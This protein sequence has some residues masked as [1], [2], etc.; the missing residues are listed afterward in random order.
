VTDPAADVITRLVR[1]EGGR[2]VAL[3]ARQTGDLDIAEEAAQEALIEAARLWP[4]GSI[5]DNPGGWLAVVARRKAIDLLRRRASRERRLAE[6]LADLDRTAPQPGED[7]PDPRLV[8]SDAI[9]DDQLRLLFLCCH[10]ALAPEAQVA[11]TLRLVAGL[12]TDEIA[13]AF[14]VSEPTLAQRLVR[15]K[16]KVR[17]ARIPLAIPDDLAER[18]DVVLG[19]IYLVFN[20]GYLARG[21]ESGHQ[22]VDLADEAIRLAR[23]LDRLSPGNAEVEGLLALMLFHHA[24]S[25]TR[26]SID[27]RL[28]PL[29]EQ[30]RALWDRALITEGDLM[31]AQALRRLAPGPYQ[32]QAIIASLHAHAPSP[33]ETDW[34]RIADHYAQLL[35]MTGSPIVAINRAIAVG[36][37]DG[38]DSGLALLA[39]V[40][41]VDHYHLVHATRAGLLDRAGRFEQA[42]DAY[43]L[44]LEHAVNPVEADYLRACL[45]R[46]SEAAG[47]TR[48][49]DASAP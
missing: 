3:L 18:R 5:P 17:D 13:G 4:A 10:P 1:E 11:L 28:V 9:A 6:A 2:L 30:D 29:E 44:A 31:L 38:P 32:V 43:R 36:M 7:A 22:R 16:R 49:R 46:T 8:T 19:V 24:R 47:P 26:T 14:L 33:A 48:Y 25:S 27:G 39:E 42:A 40:N 35:A 20:E 34:R 45:E 21:A 12:T 41:G 15:A 37:A 23:L